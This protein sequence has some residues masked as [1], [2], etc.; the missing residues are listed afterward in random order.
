[1][2]QSCAAFTRERRRGGWPPCRRRFSPSSHVRPAP[3]GELVSAAPMKSGPAAQPLPGKIA[4][5]LREAKWLALVAVA[6]YLALILGTF[7]RADPG[8]SHERRGRSHPQRRWARRRLGRRPDALPLRRFGVVVGGPAR[9]RR[10]LGLPPARR[11]VDLRQAAVHHRA[12][13]LLHAA[14]RPRAGS[15]RF[16]STRSRR[17]CR[18]RP[19]GSSAR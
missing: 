1:M 19:A 18:S 8:W 5:R 12:R 2:P 6:A 15:R 11:L 7:D 9:L 4:A 10:D 13:R 17:A 14:R 16:G 3:P